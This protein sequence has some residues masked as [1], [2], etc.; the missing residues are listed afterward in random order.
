MRPPDIA[1]SPSIVER[2]GLWP[3]PENPLIV[4]LE[5]SSGLV[6]TYIVP[7]SVLI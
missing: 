5:A 4:T 3:R 2:L 1:I 7:Q 6:E